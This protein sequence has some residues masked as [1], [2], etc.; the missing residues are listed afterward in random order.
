MKAN[1]VQHNIGAHWISLYGKKHA[2]ESNNYPFKAYYVS[3]V[4]K[5]KDENSF[6]NPLQ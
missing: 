6:H 2:Q 1:G 5:D 3:L 4:L